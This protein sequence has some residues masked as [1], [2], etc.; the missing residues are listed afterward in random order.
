[1]Q[2]RR[3][4]ILRSVLA[5]KT[6]LTSAERQLHIKKDSSEGLPNNM[7]EISAAILANVTKK[8][9]LL[10]LQRLQRNHPYAVQLQTW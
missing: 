1:M 3:R 7:C 4:P 10:D 8:R 6:R 9:P 5:M 2:K